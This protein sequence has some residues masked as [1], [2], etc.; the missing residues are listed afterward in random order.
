MLLAAPGPAGATQ[1]NAPAA[2]AAPQV[3]LQPPTTDAAVA[4]YFLDPTDAPPLSQDAMAELLRRKI[5]YVFVIFNENESFDHEY[6]TFP[7]ANGIYSDGHSP[8][9]PNQTPGFDQAFVDSAGGHHRVTPFRLA[10]GQNAT[11]MDSVDH[12]H[13]GLAAKLAVTDGKPSMSGFAQVEYGGRTH[14]NVTA[15]TDARGKQFANLV[16]S[17]IDCDTIPFFWRYANR[18]V[19][20]DNIFA[21]ED[22]PSTPNAIALI[23][24]QAGETQW[25]RTVTAG[26][27]PPN[28]Q[29]SPLL[30]DP[31]PFWGSPLDPTASLRQPASPRESYVPANV[32]PNLTFATVLLTAAGT[33]VGEMLG[34]DRH[35]ATNQADIQRDIPAIAAFGSAP[36]AWGWYQNGY[37]LEPTDTGGIATHANY[38][39]HHQGPQYFGYLADNSKEVPNLH[40]E[41]D[42]FADVAKNRLP[43]EG[44]VFYIRG[45]FGNL[46]KLHPPIQA[47]NWPTQAAAT[48]GLTPTDIRTIEETRQ[49][50]DDHPAYAD[51]MISE[52]MTARVINAI[53][54]QPELWAQSAIIVTYDESDGFYDHVPPRILSYGPDK[55]PLSRGIRVPLLV[56]SPYAR[57]HVV[58][59]AEGDHNAVIE[60]LNAIFHLPALSTLP[61]EADALAK[62]NAPAFNRF[63][64]AGFE[65][66]YL[67]PRDSNS[68]ITDSLLSAFDPRRLSGAAP[69]LPASYATID[70][71][72]VASLPHFGGAGCASIG[73]VPEDVR[74]GISAPPPPNFN[75][76]PATLSKYN[77]PPP[78]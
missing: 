62:G 55:L 1:A 60:T 29:P 56:I 76:L 2:N 35:P 42:F 36:V 18:F 41:G 70:E 27:A 66:R 73:M 68:R 19:L 43:A 47:T 57:T 30:K 72:V 52:A 21:T 77:L 9:A 40:G 16:M 69:P 59:H 65:Q 5:R 10:P 28:H 53:A 6:G 49:G 33:H 22:T 31:V 32:A 11:F 45:G 17:Y 46:Q 74:Q 4:R 44:G 71:N 25:V 26:T 38:V 75:S 14:G 61:D 48:G 7:G 50:D 67:G 24:G 63:A 20:F 58:S 3:T 15:T 34:G 12:S 39:A 13:T 37:D 51:H 8:R 78:P 64:P 54:S 23:A